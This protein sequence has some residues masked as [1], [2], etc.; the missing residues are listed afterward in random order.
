ME[1]RSAW[2]NQNTIEWRRYLTSYGP[3][4]WHCAPAQKKRRSTL[5][6][7]TESILPTK[8][9]IGSVR[10]IGFSQEVSDKDLY[11]NLD[12]LDEKR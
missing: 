8:L 5:F 12:L 2:E 3:I 1:S 9:F 6:F 4:E 7:G 10:T 11:H